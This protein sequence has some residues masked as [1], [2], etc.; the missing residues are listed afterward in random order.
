MAYEF[1]HSI[2][3]AEIDRGWSLS[4]LTPRYKVPGKTSEVS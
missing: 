3:A 1:V 2:K 4:I